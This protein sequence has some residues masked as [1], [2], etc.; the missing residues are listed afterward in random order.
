MTS[1]NNIVEPIIVKGYSNWIAQ[2]S[3]N[4]K[5]HTILLRTSNENYTN[6]LLNSIS[7]KTMLIGIFDK[8]KDIGKVFD[9]RKSIR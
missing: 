1:K 4:Y 8:D 6:A 3:I 9:R 2:L 7:T 5:P